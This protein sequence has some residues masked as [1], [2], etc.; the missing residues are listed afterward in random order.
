MPVKP[1]KRPEWKTGLDLPTRKAGEKEF[2]KSTKVHSMEIFR[3]PN[4]DNWLFISDAG[5][6]A[7]T[8]GKIFAGRSGKDPK[9]VHSVDLAVRKGGTKDWKEAPKFGLEVYFDSTS[10]NFIYITENG[11][12]SI[13]PEPKE[14]AA[15]K[16]KSPDWLHGLDLS[17]RKSEEKSF[18][19][20]TRK[21][22]IEVYNDSATGV[23]IFISETGS[24]AV[25]PA[26][27]A[28][29]APTPNVK[30][31]LWTH[32]LNV[33]CRKARGRILHRQDRH[34]RRGSFPRSECRHHHLHQ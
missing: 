20:G 18:T 22:G 32:G 24:I 4:A 16:S 5:R 17:C 34:I 1:S 14:V 8:T 11:F 7:A 13:I 26:P 27:S 30:E 23:L 25:V 31:P 12:F 3:D 2:K 19:K 10:G 29:K 28:I 15:I 33:K 21:F 6:I 9:W